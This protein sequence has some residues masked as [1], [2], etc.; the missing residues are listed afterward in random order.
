MELKARNTAIEL[1]KDGMS[2]EKIKKYTG[3]SDEQIELLR[4]EA[5]TN[6]K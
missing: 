1:I 2:N 3:F 6:N 4:N 5:K